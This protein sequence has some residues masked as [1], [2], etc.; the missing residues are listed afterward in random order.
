VIPDPKEGWLKSLTV[1]HIWVFDRKTGKLHKLLLETTPDHF[2]AATVSTDGKRLYATSRTPPRMGK[3]KDG[4]P[5]RGVFSI[6]QCW[7]TNDWK[8]AW[9]AEGQLGAPWAL[10]MSP[11]GKRVAVSDGAGVWLFDGT[12]GEPR[13]GLVKYSDN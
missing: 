11:D 2:M 7:N 1:G 10:G 3:L 9:T 5:F 12:K 6:V 13:G 8:L 4:T